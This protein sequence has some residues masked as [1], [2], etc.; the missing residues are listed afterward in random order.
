MLVLSRAIGEQISIGDTITVPF[1][2]LGEADWSGSGA[3][4]HDCPAPKARKLKPRADGA[5]RKTS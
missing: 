3:A 5:K 1:I 4:S 2:A